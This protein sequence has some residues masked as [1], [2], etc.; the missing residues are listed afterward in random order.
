MQSVS[1]LNQDLNEAGLIEGAILSFMKK[2][3][4]GCE[5]FWNACIFD[6][7]LQQIWWGDINITRQ[8]ESLQRIADQRRE[9]IYVTR[10]HGFRWDGL[11][12]KVAKQARKAGVLRE[13][14]SAKVYAFVPEEPEKWFPFKKR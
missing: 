2:A 10:E 13:Y 9:V 4:E 1:T 8:A 7:D 5:V 12:K 14:G 3:P 11:D 6:K